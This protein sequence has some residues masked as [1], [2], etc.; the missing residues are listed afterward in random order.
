MDTS[1]SHYVFV[2]IIQKMVGKSF[3]LRPTKQQQRFCL[4]TQYS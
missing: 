2:L 3:Y 1:G 4:S